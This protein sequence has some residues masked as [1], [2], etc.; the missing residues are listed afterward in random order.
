MMRLASSETLVNYCLF[1]RFFCCPLLSNS[2]SH[3]ENGD[4]IKT[5]GKGVK[6]EMG[7]WNGN[8]NGSND[9]QEE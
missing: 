3:R 8:G 1:A 5:P 4:E 6:K 7:G 2:G 9:R